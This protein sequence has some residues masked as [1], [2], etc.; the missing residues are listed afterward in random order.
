MFLRALFFFSQFFAIYISIFHKTDV[1]TVIL[2]CWTGL[3]HNWFKSYDTKRKWGDKQSV[4]SIVVSFFLP[5]VFIP[6]WLSSVSEYQK[7]LYY[8]VNTLNHHVHFWIQ[9][10]NDFFSLFTEIL[11]LKGRPHFFWG[12]Q[13]CAVWPLITPILTGHYATTFCSKQTLATVFS[14]LILW[15]WIQPSM[16]GLHFK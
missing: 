2:K 10:L 13:Q 7:I 9:A 14:C 1:L 15:H 16:V 6:L 4:L 11:D 5:L 12:W 8:I 3:N